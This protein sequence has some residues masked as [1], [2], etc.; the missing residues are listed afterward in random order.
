[1]ST[2]SWLS[3]IVFSI[4]NEAINR[5]SAPIARL[6]APSFVYGIDF[7]DHWSFN[8]HG[9]PAVMLTDTAF[10]RNPHYHKPTDHPNT[11]DY[12]RAAKVINGL[13]GAVLSLAK[14]RC[15]H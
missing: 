4:P 14:M 2:K 15:N 12:K 10:Y 5:A 3:G 11:L 6:N 9:Y 1:M 13:T 8:R 7:S